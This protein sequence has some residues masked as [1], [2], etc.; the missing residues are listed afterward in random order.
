M[1]K[2]LEISHN[3]TAV[4]GKNDT[5]ARK[6]LGIS[7]TDGTDQDMLLSRHACLDMHVVLQRKTLNPGRVNQK[8]I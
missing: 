7:T 5:E 6:N 3:N 1:I 4:E 2:N 8:T